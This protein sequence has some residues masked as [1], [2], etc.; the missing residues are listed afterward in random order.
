M[1]LLL[2]RIGGRRFTDVSCPVETLMHAAPTSHV[3]SSGAVLASQER[4]GV[5]FKAFA[6]V[7]YDPEAENP[8]DTLSAPE[9]RARIL[10]GNYRIGQ[11]PRFL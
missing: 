4:M 6:W 8:G 11:S 1:S 10:A 5:D 7:G 2:Q 3:L 9:Q